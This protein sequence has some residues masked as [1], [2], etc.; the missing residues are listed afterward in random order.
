MAALRERGLGGSAA[1]NFGQALDL[2]VGLAE[3]GLRT[4]ADLFQHGQNDA[5]FVFEQRR[6]Q[7]QGQQFRIAVLGG[8]LVAALHRFLRLHGEFFPTDRHKNSIR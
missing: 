3:N 8:E 1:G 4:D 5:F 2:A 7:V 6:Q